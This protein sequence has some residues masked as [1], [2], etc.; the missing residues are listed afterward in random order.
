MGY[1]VF[2]KH[3]YG[4]L[5][6]CDEKLLSDSEYLREVVSEAAR[7]GNMTLLDIRVWRIEPGV[8]IVGIV[9][10]SHI[11]IHTWP[12]HG[13]AAVDVYSCGEHTNPEAAF[14][15]IVKAL[16]AKRYEYEVADRSYID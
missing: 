10:E 6:G 13:F 4:N 8:S 11:T 5:Y 15:Y 1:K 16:K 12:E 2:G 9:L 14:K 7:V 3:V